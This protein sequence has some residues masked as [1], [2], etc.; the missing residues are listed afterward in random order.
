MSDDPSKRGPA[1]ATRVN[2]HEPYEVAYW[3]KRFGV[4]ADQLKK[5]VQKVGVMVADVQKCLGK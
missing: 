5:C 1:D 4:T 3:T 2:I